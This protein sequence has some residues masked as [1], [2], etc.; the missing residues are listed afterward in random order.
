MCLRSGG[1]SVVLA[2]SYKF[3][4]EIPSAP[5]TAD[6][7]CLPLSA[8]VSARAVF[9][10]ARWIASFKISASIVFL[11][12][13]RSNSRIRDNAAL[14]SLA[15]TT[16]SL[17]RTATCPPFWNCFLR[18]NSWLAETPYFQAMEDILLPGLFS[19]SEQQLLLVCRPPASTFH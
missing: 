13:W 5:A 15:G 12:S 2:C 14:C 3:D 1:F 16:S 11:P 7:V 9:S 18:A 19:F 10:L 8:I 4:F 17:A 6:R